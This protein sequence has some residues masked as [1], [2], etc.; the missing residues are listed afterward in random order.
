MRSRDFGACKFSWEIERNFYLF[1]T[2]FT[3]PFFYIAIVRL[4]VTMRLLW[5]ALVHLPR[6][7]SPLLV[8]RQQVHLVVQMLVGRLLMV[9]EAPILKKEG[10]Y[11]VQVLY[12]EKTFA[13]GA[14]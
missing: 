7:I 1:L 3:V 8:T 14:K 4:S 5:F 9:L 13:L 2:F 6:S 12:P 10:K 11:A